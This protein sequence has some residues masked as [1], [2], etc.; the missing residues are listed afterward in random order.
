MHGKERKNMRK[1]NGER[2]WSEIY[3]GR[4]TGRQAWVLMSE[5]KTK[6]HT[7]A[8]SDELKPESMWESLAICSGSHWLTWKH[9]ET[10]WGIP[11]TIPQLVFVGFQWLM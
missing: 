7:Q 2:R 3:T 9:H 10:W 4:R 11:A 6:M 1:M 8:F 5:W